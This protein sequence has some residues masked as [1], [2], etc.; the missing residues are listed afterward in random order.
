VFNTQVPPE[1]VTRWVEDGA[2]AASVRVL[3]LRNNQLRQLPPG[4]T[5]SLP[6]LSVAFV[7]SP[8]FRFRSSFM[9]YRSEVRESERRERGKLTRGLV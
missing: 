7:L 2:F 1:W 5:L 3:S 6:Y 8:F 9:C 4:T